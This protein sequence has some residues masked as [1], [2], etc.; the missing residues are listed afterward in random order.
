MDFTSHWHGSWMLDWNQN[1]KIVV[2]YKCFCP[3]NFI[4]SRF[5]VPHFPL[6]RKNRASYE[7]S[8]IACVSLWRYCTTR[9][10][11]NTVCIITTMGRVGFSLKLFTFATILLNEKKCTSINCT[12]KTH[13]T[14]WLKL[15]T[16]T[17]GLQFP[18]CQ[19]VSCKSK[20]SPLIDALS[21]IYK[22]GS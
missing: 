22:P 11:R 17:D 20:I 7:K 18:M 2:T 8:P 1:F 4:H 6:F 3:K 19:L 16:K 9:D 14:R 13:W 5:P 12:R 21:D 15:R 10:D